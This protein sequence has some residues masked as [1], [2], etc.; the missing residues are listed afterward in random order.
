M[1]DIT[2]EQLEL[3]LKYLPEAEALLDDPDGMYYILDLLDDKMLE[4]GYDEDYELN[5]VGAKLEDLYDDL[6]YQNVGDEDED[7]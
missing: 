1:F 6:Y 4:L 7:E 5:E 2:P 3:L